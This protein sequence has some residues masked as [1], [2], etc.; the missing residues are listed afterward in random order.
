MIIQ[1]AKI[2][3]DTVK[4]LAY[5]SNEMFYMFSIMHYAQCQGAPDI[6]PRKASPGLV[7]YIIIA[8]TLNRLGYR[9]MV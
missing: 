1:M 6:K 8:P 3:F 9:C 2:G 7:M 4:H 5:D